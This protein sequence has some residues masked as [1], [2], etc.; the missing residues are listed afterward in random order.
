MKRNELQQLID[1][2]K[3]EHGL[4]HS[5]VTKSCIRQ[6]VQKNK[7]ERSKTRGTISPMAPAE[8]YIYCISHDTD[9]KNAAAH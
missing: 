8:N 1:D 4:T 5:N 6:R 3:L 9:G 2:K 7:L